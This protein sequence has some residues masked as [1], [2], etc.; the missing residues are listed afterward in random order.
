MKPVEK[1]ERL[2]KKGRY[3]ATPEA[4]D[5]ILDSFLQAVDSYEKQK[6]ALTEPNIWRIIMKNPVTKLAVA[7]V[8]VVA[9]LAGVFQFGNR[10]NMESVAFADVFRPLLTAETGTFNMTIDVVSAGLDWI[11]CKGEPVQT[12]EVMFAGPSLT[13]WDVPT[14]EVLVANMQAG[15]VMILLPAKKEAVFMQVG[16][17]GVTPKNNRFNKLLAL[18]PL[19][20]YA[21]EKN[22]D[23][24]QFLGERQI[25]GV[26]VIGYHLAGPDHHGEITVWA[27]P[28]TRLPIRIE[29][30]MYIEN[31]KETAVITGI[32]YNVEL[33]ESLISVGLPE[34]YSV[35]TSK[36][37]DAHPPFNVGGTVTDAATGQPI[38]GAKVSDDGYGPKPYK[39]AITDAEGRYSYF[40]WPEEHAIIAQAPGYKPQRKNIKAGLF[41]T[42]N[43][44]KTQV[45]HF[46]LDS[47]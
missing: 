22:P 45:I 47:R 15:K 7:A 1:I 14:G 9:V 38:A 32:E 20:R 21:L 36:D 40:T 30:S 16:Q 17:P 6:S 2:I 12:I 41:H 29:Q 19:I 5:R 35:T 39:G 28:E 27:D 11:D 23:S 42:E 34:G 44:E 3:K 8:I 31:R 10:I 37:E 46:A 43:V 13:R 25:E 33:D 18:R 24:V 26:T 4:Y